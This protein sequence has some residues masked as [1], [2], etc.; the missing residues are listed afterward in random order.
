MAIAAHLIAAAG[1]GDTAALLA[2]DV[3][4]ADRSAE[5]RV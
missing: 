3:A 2:I 1:R 4:L 5:Q